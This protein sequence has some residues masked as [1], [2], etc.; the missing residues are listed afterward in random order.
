MEFT[1]H[2]TLKEY[3]TKYTEFETSYTTA[4]TDSVDHVK[5]GMEKLNVDSDVQEFLKT[6]ET[7][8]KDPGS[9]AFEPSHGDTVCG[10]VLFLS[11]GRISHQEFIVRWALARI[12]WF[13][14]RHP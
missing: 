2:K 10:I 9:F 1:Y 11:I 6:H 14:G 4:I 13:L 7:I 12:N 3:I 5:A 8:F